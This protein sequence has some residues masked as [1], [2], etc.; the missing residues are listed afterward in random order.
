M[1][2]LVGIYTGSVALGLLS[3]YYIIWRY[4]VRIELREKPC[5]WCGAEKEVENIAEYGLWLKSD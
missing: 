5:R 4:D 3:V 2:I 1:M